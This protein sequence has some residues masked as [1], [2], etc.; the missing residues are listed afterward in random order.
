LPDPLRILHLTAAAASGG[1]SRYLLDLA[2]AHRAAGHDVHIAG[3]DGPWRQRFEDAG[4]PYHL[5][6]LNAPPTKLLATVRQLR[7]LGDHWDILHSHYRRTTL[8][9]RLLQRRLKH[10][11]PL[12]YTL[13]LSHMPLGGL[14][15]LLADWGD[16]THCASRDAAD[17]LHTAA[18]VPPDRITV[19]P[20]G[21]DLGRHPPAT[22]AQRADAR[23]TL[24]LLPTAT[25]ALY[26]GRLETPKNVDWLADVTWTASR[27]LLVAGDGPDRPLLENRPH[28]HL[29]GETDPRPLYAAADLLLL[30]SAREGF[31]LVCAESLA[32]G[33]PILRTQTSG[34]TETVIDNVTGWS[35]PIDRAA[36]TTRSN[37]LLSDRAAL[38]ARRQPAAAHAHAH[39]GHARQTSET[40]DL[41]RKLGNLRR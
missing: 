9:G 13:H 17:W 15:R 33:T 7:Q 26:V 6:P 11:P 36:F 18:N 8:A 38:L 34:T 5:V 4:V 28:I 32:I 40:A 24:S 41:Y 39:L 23:A 16:H 31:G 22:N 2:V 30:P 10:R 20:H 1:L 37:Q 21:I 19:I 29:L 25:V 12:L 14:R 3:G 27:P 35:T